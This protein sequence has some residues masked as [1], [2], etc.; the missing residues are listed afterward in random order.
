MRNTGVKEILVGVGLFAAVAVFMIYL[1]GVRSMTS[2]AAT[3]NYTV[4]AKFNKVDGLI[5]GDEVRLGGIRVGTVESQALDSNYRAVL[6]LRMNSNVKLPIDTSAAIHTDGLFGAK[7]IVLEPGGDEKS[8]KD[9]DEITFT[10]DAIIL[11]ELLDLII[12]QGR[13]NLK[14]LESQKGKEK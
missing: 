13:A 5:P 4:I 3:Q 14:K 9:G 10:Q 7:F 1:F 2:H 11:S 6:T 12:S 8:Y